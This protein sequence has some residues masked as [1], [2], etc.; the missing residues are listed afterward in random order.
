[1][2]RILIVEDE[3]AIALGLEDDLRMEGYT[4]E[5]AG[6]SHCVYMSHPKEVVDVIESVARA[7]SK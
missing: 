4:V 6:A 2:T 1:M 5:V 7:V 3:P